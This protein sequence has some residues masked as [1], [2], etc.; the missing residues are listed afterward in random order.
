MLLMPRHTVCP[1]RCDAIPNPD[2]WCRRCKRLAYVANVT[3]IGAWLHSNLP[4]WDEAFVGLHGEVMSVA[5]GVY[6]RTPNVSPADIATAFL[7]ACE[8]AS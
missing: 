8:V 7:P 2:A 1:F 3:D 4:A 6:M 5:Y